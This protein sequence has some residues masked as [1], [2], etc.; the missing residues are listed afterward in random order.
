MGVRILPNIT[1]KAASVVWFWS[2]SVKVQFMMQR[3]LGFILFEF[4]PPHPLCEKI[5]G[6]IVL[7]ERQGSIK[8]LI[9]SLDLQIMFSL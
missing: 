3:C 7:K 2:F 1:D 9:P 6:L 4:T 8:L 5:K